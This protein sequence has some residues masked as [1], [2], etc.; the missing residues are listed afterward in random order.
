MALVPSLE[1][2][3]WQEFWHV[4]RKRQNDR[5]TFTVKVAGCQIDNATSFSREDH[6]HG[7]RK[8]SLCGEVF[9]DNGRVFYA[10]VRGRWEL[11]RSLLSKKQNAFAKDTRHQQNLIHR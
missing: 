6:F 1:M 5:F 9:R 11:A 8:K 4:G 3:R 2:G 7:C 10:I